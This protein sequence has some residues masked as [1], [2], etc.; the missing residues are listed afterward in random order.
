MCKQKRKQTQIDDNKSIYNAN[1]QKKHSMNFEIK[2]NKEKN[3]S[4]L[5]SKKNNDKYRILCN[6][7]NNNNS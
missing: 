5:T 6:Q 3:L 7:H 2:I 1:K 4:S